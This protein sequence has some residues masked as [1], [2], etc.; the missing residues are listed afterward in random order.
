MVDIQYSVSQGTILGPLLFLLYIN[1]LGNCSSSQSL[2]YL[3]MIH[4]WHYKTYHLL[5]I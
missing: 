5:K 1:D 4:A 2:S 3:H